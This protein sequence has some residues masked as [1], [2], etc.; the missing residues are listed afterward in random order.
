MR[1]LWASN[2]PLDSEPRPV[3]ML[4]PFVSMILVIYEREG[5]LVG[6]VVRDKDMTSLS[7]I[8]CFSLYSCYFSC[9]VAILL[10]LSLVRQ[11][12][13]LSL[14]VN[15]QCLWFF[16]IYHSNIYFFLLNDYLRASFWIFA[17]G[18]ELDTF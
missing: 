2:L 18:N 9:T 11:K 4:P 14:K 6:L 7:K 10:S 17:L 5:R 16:L 13:V 15:E 8:F 12:E 1:I 3:V